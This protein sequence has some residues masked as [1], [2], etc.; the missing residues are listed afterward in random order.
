[1]QYANLGNSNLTGADLQSF[2][3]RGS[4][5]VTNLSNA[6]LE[7][8]D[9]TGANLKGAVLAGAVMPDGSINEEMAS[10]FNSSS[11]D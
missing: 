11:F 6:N 4:K 1:L 8:A 2:F 9:L 5:Q 3:S 7:G 10:N